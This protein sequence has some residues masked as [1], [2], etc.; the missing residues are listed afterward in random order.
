[1]GKSQRE[2]GRRA[3]VELAALLTESLGV[4]VK[5]NLGQARDSGDDITVGKF[6]IE[7]KRHNRLSVMEWCRQV[8]E[9]CGD[10]DVPIVAFRQDG[11]QW[12]VV[13]R[14]DDLLPM[15]RGEL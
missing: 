4:A 12:R 7:C 13:M 14:L 3:E 5:R 1:M 8:E 10:G 6:R 11:Q 2:K 9:A 15:L